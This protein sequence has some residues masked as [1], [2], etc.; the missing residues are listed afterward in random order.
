M[1]RLMKDVDKTGLTRDSYVRSLIQGHEPKELPPVEYHEV[2]KQLRQINNNLN[3][4]AVVANVKGFIDTKAYWDNV[5][6]L[7]KTVGEMME[8]MYG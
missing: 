7:Q 1:N 6:W 4:I 3:Q 2:L 5:E 8:V